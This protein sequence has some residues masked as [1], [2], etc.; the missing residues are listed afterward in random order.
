VINTHESGD[1]LNKGGNNS[2][3]ESERSPDWV[4]EG[5]HRAAK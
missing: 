2:A 1:H 4:K 5:K 3:S